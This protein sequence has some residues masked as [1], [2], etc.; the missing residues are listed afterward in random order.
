MDNSNILLIIVPKQSSY[1]PKL[2]ISSEVEDYISK[3][4]K[5]ISH[6]SQKFS[7][8]SLRVH[9]ERSPSWVSRHEPRNPRKSFDLSSTCPLTIPKPFSCHPSIPA[10]SHII[11]PGRGLN[12]EIR[13]SQSRKRVAASRGEGEAAIHEEERQRTG[14]R[15]GGE[16]GE[17]C[18]SGE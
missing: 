11:T 14:R 5:I 13:A 18:F 10:L 4:I 15:W 2:I 12:R 17:R 9:N 7:K 1:Q 3:W 8:K 16:W 6:S